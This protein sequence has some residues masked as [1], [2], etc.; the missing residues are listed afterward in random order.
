M[1]AGLGVVSTGSASYRNEGGD[2]LALFLNLSAG[3]LVTRRSAGRVERS[4]PGFGD[5]S[6]ATPAFQAEVE[7][8]DDARLAWFCAGWNSVAGWLEE[9]GFRPEGLEFLPRLHMRD[10]AILRLV[11]AARQRAGQ[12]EEAEGTG[13]RRSNAVKGCPLVTVADPYRPEP[14][15][16]DRETAPAFWLVAT[17]WMPMATGHQTGNR[18]LPNEQ[19]MP[20]GLGPPT[21]RHPKANEGFYVLDGLSAAGHATRDEQVGQHTHEVFGL[22]LAAHP[23]G[24]AHSGELVHQ[25]EHPGWRFGRGKLPGTVHFRCRPEYRF[26]HSDG[27]SDKGQASMTRTSDGVRLL[28]RRSQSRMTKPA[29]AGRFKV[30]L[31]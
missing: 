12:G 17:L 30:R 13:R 16:L 22:E 31:M 26:S 3:H 14:Y 27:G 5:A 4:R 8:A 2:R 25:V 10:H 7:A 6:V 15:V 19:W 23:D 21:H 1:P 20:T 11:A 29:V 18:F 24:Q 9:A 28:R